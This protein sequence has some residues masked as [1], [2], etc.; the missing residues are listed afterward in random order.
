LEI[1]ELDVSDVVLEYQ[2]GAEETKEHIANMIEEKIDKLKE[3]A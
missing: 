2:D 1:E 3:G